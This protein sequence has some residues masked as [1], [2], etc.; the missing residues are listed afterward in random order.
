MLDDVLTSPVED[1][2]PQGDLSPPPVRTL[3]ISALVLAMIATCH[4]TLLAVSAFQTQRNPSSLLTLHTSISLCVFAG[5]G[6]LLF[7]VWTV[8]SPDVLAELFTPG[9]ATLSVI[10]AQATAACCTAW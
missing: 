5:C 8:T 9:L 10:L 1:V 7:N 6:A 2:E 4:M 3:M